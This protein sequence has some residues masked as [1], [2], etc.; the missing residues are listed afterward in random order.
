MLATRAQ[1][2]GSRES[3]ARATVLTALI[4]SSGGALAGIA[5]GLLFIGTRERDE[6]AR[7]SA[8][9]AS[10][11]AESDDAE[12]LAAPSQEDPRDRDQ[13]V[14]RAAGGAPIVP[15]GS[16]APDGVRTARRR[17]LH[18]FLAQYEALADR[19]A[20]SLW[21]GGPSAEQV[22]GHRQSLLQGIDLLSIATILDSQGRFEVMGDRFVKGISEVPGELRFG[23]NGRL[24]TVAVQEFPEFHRL[25]ALM[26][27][28][29]RGHHASGSP[30]EELSELEGVVLERMHEAHRLLE[31]E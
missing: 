15:G 13:P 29:D 14:A 20:P 7:P 1:L 25:H 26:S 18:Q 8:R 5:V 12:P 19:G 9:D 21:P 30:F 6:V 22:M 10:E 24:Y 31:K 23:S 3:R 16:A 28:G 2:A 27:R 17:S 4:C 11:R